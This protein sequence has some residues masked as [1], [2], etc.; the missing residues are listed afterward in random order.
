MSHGS[1]A[2]HPLSFRPDGDTWVIGR[3]DT[4]EFAA[5][6]AVAHRVITLLCDGH[7]IEAT[8]RA[9]RQETGTEFAV[10]DFVAALDELGFVAA[11]DGERRAETEPPRPTMPWL[12]PRHVRWMLHPV[13]AWLALAVI[14]AGVVLLITS[15]ALAPRY[16]DLVWSR[17]SGLVTVVY[18]GLGW[19]LVWLHE[20]GHLG[21]A[22]AAGVP[23]R[24]SLGTRLQFLVAQTDVS[25]VWAAPRRTRWTVYLAGITVNLLVA[26]LGILLEPLVAPGLPRHILAAAALESVLF[27]PFELLVFMRTDLY[28]LIQDA[29]GCANLY[30]DG[31]AHLRYLARRALARGTAGR[32]GAAAGPDPARALPPRE[33]R[34]VRAYSWLLLTGTVTCL[35]AAVFITVPAAVVVLAHAF[36]EVAGGQL[37]DIVDGLA[38]IAVFGAFQLLW[39][40]TWWRRHGGRVRGYL[41]SRPSRAAEGR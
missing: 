26:A 3:I 28:F 6:P 21:T 1:V 4:G 9:L 23:A 24:M 36:G 14:A 40:W 31:S 38:A 18:V 32:R 41:P 16:Y 19:G 5:M 15:P 2:F 7:T 11:L 27:L 12:R 8:A 20:F 10:S 37:A 17:H 29:T 22:R 34:A 33:R 39:L 13:T 35:A 25:G 30:A